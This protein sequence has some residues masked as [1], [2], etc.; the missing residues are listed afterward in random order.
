MGHPGVNNDYLV[1]MQHELAMRYNDTSPLENMHCARLFQ[2]IREEQSNIFANLPRDRIKEVRAMC[3]EVILHTDNI[4]HVAMLKNV[5]LW[6]EVHREMLDR[7]AVAW[8]NPQKDTTQEGTTQDAGRTSVSGGT[9][10]P[11]Q[12][13]TDSMW[14][15]ETRRMIRNV[16]LHFTDNS[17]PLK[18]FVLCKEW[19]L[20]ILEE[21]FTQGDLEQQNNLPVQPLNDRSKTNVPFSQISFIEFF[22]APLMIATVRILVPLEDRIEVLLSNAVS[23]M[24]EW[25]QGDGVT[26]EELQQVRNR[27]RRLEEKVKVP[28]VRREE[29]SCAWSRQNSSGQ[30]TSQS[31]SFGYSNPGASSVPASKGWFDRGVEYKRSGVESMPTSSQ[32]SSGRSMS[33]FAAFRKFSV[34]A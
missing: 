13:L 10:W 25:A 8:W 19:S 4:H 18:N 30:L 21:F 27:L 17:H 34:K 22:A 9:R 28:E 3:V 20:R 5:Q 2:L 32:A 23:W 7:A 29:P 24:E 14:E 6:S 31:S 15:Q 12:E 16:I 26:Q 11:T 33:G 1:Q